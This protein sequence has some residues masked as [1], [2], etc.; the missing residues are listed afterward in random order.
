MVDFMIVLIFTLVCLYVVV[1]DF[2]LALGFIELSSTVLNDYK[3][4]MFYRYE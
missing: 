2:E 1:N 4:H 3:L